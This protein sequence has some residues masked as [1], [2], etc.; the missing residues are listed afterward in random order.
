M[1]TGHSEPPSWHMKVDM[2]GISAHT[3]GWTQSGNLAH[4]GSL[5]LFL[6]CVSHSEEE[7]GALNLLMKM[8]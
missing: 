3:Q 5:P 6:D 4:T 1:P 7:G 2:T 8:P